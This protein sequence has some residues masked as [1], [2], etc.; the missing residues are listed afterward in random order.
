MRGIHD[1][2]DGGVISLLARYAWP[3]S[4]AINAAP[5]KLPNDWHASF[6][7]IG[8]GSGTAVSVQAVHVVCDI[9]R[10]LQ[11]STLL[12]KLAAFDAD[13]LAHVG[14]EFGLAPL[15]SHEQKQVGCVE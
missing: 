14:D 2:S 3:K 7:A 1:S 10:A 13:G 11:H 4:H 12:K 6:C 15:G 9:E 5:F 8:L